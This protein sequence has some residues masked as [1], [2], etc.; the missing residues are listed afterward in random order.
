LYAGGFGSE[1][2]GGANFAVGDGSLH[3]IPAA[4]DPKLYQQCGYR[5]HVKL[6]DLLP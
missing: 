6:P 1:H 5:A 2:S 3:Y 4:V